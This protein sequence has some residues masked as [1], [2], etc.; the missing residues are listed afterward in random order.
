[1]STDDELTWA[2]PGELARR[3]RA[4]DVHPRELVGHF[5]ARIA[6]LDPELNAFRDVLAA[7]AVAAAD[8]PLEGPLAG[9]P[10]AVKDDLAAADAEVVRRLRAAGA[11][12][13]GITN[14]P[15]LMIWPWTST[16]ANG[17]TRNPWDPTRT[18]G[19]SSG[20]SAAAVAAGMVPVATASDGGGSI[21]IPAACCGLVGLK[22]TRGL[23]PTAPL[24]EAWLGLSTFGA[25]TR[26]VADTA[27]LLDVLAGPAAGDRYHHERDPRPYVETAAAAPGRLRIAVSRK[28]PPGALARLAPEQAAA[29]DRTAATL[30]SLGH[31]VDERDPDMGTAGLDF[32][33]QYV[34][35]VAADLAR[36]PPGGPFEPSTRQWAALGRLVSPKRVDKLRARRADLARR[37]GRLWDEADVLVT[38]VLTRTPVAAEGAHGRSAPAAFALASSFA[39]WPSLW[40]L[41]GQPALAVP[42]GLADDGLPVAAQLVGRHGDE[43]RLLS[44]GAQLEAEEGWP[45]RRPALATGQPSAA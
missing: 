20:G 30:R 9:V 38:P 5:L 11:I 17:T 12:P 13:I 24:A 36:M 7:E 43:G 41:T 3:V 44:L 18:P 21:R 23:V 27:L 32:V 19:G 4:G 39:P 26:T 35:G 1:M 33:P 34:A 14:V 28:L 10:V 16:D 37:V 22:A 15:E 29:L 45:A 42:A 40:N 31:D 8:L 2:G 25:L 6:E